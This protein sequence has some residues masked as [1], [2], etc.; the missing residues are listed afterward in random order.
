MA[1]SNIKAGIEKERVLDD[2]HCFAISDRYFEDIDG[3]VAIPKYA[4]C[5]IL[6]Y[7]KEN[8]CYVKVKFE[9]Y[10]EPLFTASWLLRTPK[11]IEL[12]EKQLEEKS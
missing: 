8:D 1:M 4:K 3:I 11:Q 2:K 12:L 6:E 5:I 9:D 10:P 7:L